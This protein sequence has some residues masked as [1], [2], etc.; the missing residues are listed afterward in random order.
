MGDRRRG[1]E[2]G[3]ETD[4]GKKI[5]RDDI[6][7][8]LLLINELFSKDIVY[9]V[10]GKICWLHTIWKI[11]CL[12]LKELGPPGF[13]WQC[14]NNRGTRITRVGGVKNGGTTVE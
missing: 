8:G 6:F 2:E 13:T 11:L 3:G 1:G 4:G 9:S 5:L 14:G 7:L 10:D 12:L